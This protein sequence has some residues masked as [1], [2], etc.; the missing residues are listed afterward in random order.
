MWVHREVSLSIITSSILRFES[1]RNITVNDATKNNATC[2]VQIAAVAAG[3]VG[4]AA[5]AAVVATAAEGV[6]AALSE[7]AGVAGDEVA[8]VLSFFEGGRS[9]L[10]GSS[11]LSLS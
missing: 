5:A 11:S 8:A 4:V 3:D 2:L 1:L 6:E 9:S 7:A 10:T